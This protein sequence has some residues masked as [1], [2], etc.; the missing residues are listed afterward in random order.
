[1]KIVSP[2]TRKRA[3]TVLDLLMVIAA[4]TFIAIVY[5]SHTDRNV[6]ARALRVQCLNNLKQTGQAFDM[7]AKDHGEKFPMEISQTNGGTM[8]FTTGP[9][10]W[11]HFQVMSNELSTPMALRCP[12]EKSRMAATNFTSLRN[13]N[14]SYFIN[15]DF[16]RPSP[17][18]IW[19]GDRNLDN[20]EPVRDGV[21]EL[22]TN[23]PAAW[24]AEMHH[25]EGN[26]LMFDGSV[27]RVDEAS[28]RNA[29]ANSGASTNRL[30]MPVLSP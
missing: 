18:V 4:I 1:M 27:Q 3:F 19:S 5:L 12:S 15:L 29:I 24:T 17:Q 28:L 8:E 23:P 10:E 25:K 20:G 14:I 2:T 13:S 16:S 9:N 26:L 11:R 6:R 7:W 30:Q 22:T 21:L